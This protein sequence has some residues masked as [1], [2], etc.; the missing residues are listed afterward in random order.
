MY[1]DPL[2]TALVCICS[3]GRTE[4]LAVPPTVAVASICEAVP[5]EPGHVHLEGT[6]NMYTWSETQTPPYSP[7]LSEPGQISQGV[8]EGRSY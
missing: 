3:N 4:A 1:R 2:L 7:S 8:N 6:H 5:I